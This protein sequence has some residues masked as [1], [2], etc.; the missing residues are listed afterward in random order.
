MEKV[1]SLQA[2]KLAGSAKNSSFPA[3][4]AFFDPFLSKL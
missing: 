3:F 2:K 4:F 1:L